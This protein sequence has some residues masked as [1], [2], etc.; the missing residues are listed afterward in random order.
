MHKDRPQHTLC[1]VRVSQRHGIRLEACSLCVCGFS[2]Q[3]VTRQQYSKLLNHR[4]DDANDEA[5]NN[6][7]DDDE[8]KEDDDDENDEEDDD[9][10]GDDEDGTG[11]M[12][13]PLL[14]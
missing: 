4:G 14:V 5:E 7:D 3:S 6:D 2:I 9:N 1:C 11:Q 8:E 12:Q 13:L 10:S